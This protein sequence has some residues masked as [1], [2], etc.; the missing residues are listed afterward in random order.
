MKFNKNIKTIFLDIDS[1][2]IEIDEKVNVILSPSLYWVKKLPLPVKYARDA[3]KL[4]PSIFDDT[5]TEGNY[6]YSVYKEGDEFVVFAY[7]D[8]AILSVL[9][10]K[11]ILISNVANVFFAQSEL[12]FIEGAYKV[13]ETQSI[14]LKDDILIL[15]PCCW[16]EE[17]GDLKLEEVSLSKHSITLAQFGHIIDNKSIYKIGAILV[18]LIMLVSVELYITNTKANKAEELKSTLFQKAKLQST[19]FQNRALL[20][21]YNKIH[22]VQKKIREI[23]SALLSTKLASSENLSKFYL[24]EKKLTAQFTPLSQ[25]S[26]DALKK[27]LKA[28]K[29]VFSTKQK[30]DNMIFEMRL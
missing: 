30:K 29:I 13:N 26:I 27:R 24:K 11:G 12:N 3:K 28:N 19:M 2:L 25:K 6:N 20:K 5:L 18:V 8:R 10:A 15:L 23:S 14:F 17:S 16:I 4:L 7:D 9:E 22:T 21:K 1:P